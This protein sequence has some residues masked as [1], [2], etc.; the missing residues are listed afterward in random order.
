MNWKVNCF[1]W[2]KN[3]RSQFKCHFDTTFLNI[4][5]AAHTEMIFKETVIS[6]NEHVLEIGVIL[7]LKLCCGVIN[8]GTNA[9]ETKGVDTIMRRGRRLRSALIW[10]HEKV[11]HEMLLDNLSLFCR[12]WQKVISRKDEC[13]TWLLHR[14]EIC[15]NNATH[16]PFPFSEFSILHAD[17]PP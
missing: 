7:V 5:R 6:V 17:S 16:A 3:T 2:K 10:S 14:T 1:P 9:V 12:Q 11:Y 4:K 8:T 15:N 13:F